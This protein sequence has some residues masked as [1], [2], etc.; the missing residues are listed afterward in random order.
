MVLCVVSTRAVFEG[1]NKA[2]DVVWGY[3]NNEGVG[4]DCK[5]TDAFENPMPDTCQTKQREINTLQYLIQIKHDGLNLDA[6][7]LRYLFLTFSTFLLCM[8]FFAS[9]QNTII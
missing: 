4:D 1:I 3:G 7:V 6:N 5:H 9:L 2:G 8:G